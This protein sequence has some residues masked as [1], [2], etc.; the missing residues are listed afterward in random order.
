MSNVELVTAAN[1][2]PTQ[3]LAQRVTATRLDPVNS[4]ATIGELARN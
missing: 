2:Q 3:G 4:E 1:A